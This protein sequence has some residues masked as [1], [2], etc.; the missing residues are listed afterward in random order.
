MPLDDDII[1]A[2]RKSK[3]AETYDI[4]DQLEREALSYST[5]AIL[6]HL[7]FVGNDGVVYAGSCYVV[8][9]IIFFLNGDHLPE[10]IKRYIPQ[11]YRYDQKNKEQ[12][13]IPNRFIEALFKDKIKEAYHLV[14]KVE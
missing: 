4:G 1:E 11:M 10:T 12:G 7:I 8:P 6:R 14:K 3:L 2:F 13:F 5:G 9:S